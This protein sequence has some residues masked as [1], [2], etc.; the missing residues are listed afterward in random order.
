MKKDRHQEPFVLE[1]EA[2]RH[3]RQEME[4][5]DREGNSDERKRFLAE[6]ERIY[7]ELSGSTE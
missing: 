5:L 1:G 7:R 2:A 6:C 4:R 3:V